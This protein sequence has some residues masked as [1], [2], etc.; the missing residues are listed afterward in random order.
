M[1]KKQNIL[2][3]MMSEILQEISE[4]KRSKRTTV[5][6]DDETVESIFTKFNLPIDCEEDLQRLERGLENK[7]DFNKTV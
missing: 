4:I 7:A 1:I 2:Q 5:D 3:G 6:D